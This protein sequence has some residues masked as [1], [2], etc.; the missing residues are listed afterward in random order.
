MAGKPLKFTLSKEAVA[1]LQW[2]AKTVLLEET[3]DQAARHLV[4][5]QVEEI[6]RAHRKD[7]PNPADLPTDENS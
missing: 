4:L 2:Y 7:D 3:A 6:R 5:K 1:Y